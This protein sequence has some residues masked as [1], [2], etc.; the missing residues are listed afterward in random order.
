MRAL[1]FARP[2]GFLVLG[3][4]AALV[5]PVTAQQS[6]DMAEA[7]WDLMTGSPEQHRAAIDAIVARNDPDMIPALILAMRFRRTEAGLLSRSAE[8][9]TGARGT[10][11]FDWMLW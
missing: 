11:W 4:G 7:S 8:A 6:D 3:I 9:I 2:L 5:A 1:T 10:G